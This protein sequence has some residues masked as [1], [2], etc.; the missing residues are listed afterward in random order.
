[1][2]GSL[3]RR[4][5]RRRAARRSLGGDVALWYHP[6]YAPALLARTCRVPSVPLRRGVLVLGELVRLGLLRAADVRAPQLASSEELLRVHPWNYLEDVARPEV[7][8]HIFGLDD[9]AAEADPLLLAQ[10]WAVGGT[11]A[12]ARAAAGLAGAP[13]KV[14]VNLGG[15]FHHAEPERG[16]GFCVYND[17][18]VAVAA[19]RDA[20]YDEPIAIVDLDF[21]QGDGNLVTFADDPSVLTFSLHGSV[22]SHIEAVA[23]VGIELA[24]GTGD[25]AYLRLL[26]EQLPAALAAHEPGL[27]FFLSGTDVL[28]GD[29]LG[30]FALSPAGVLARDRFVVESAQAQGCAL[31]VTLAGGYRDD[32]WLCTASLLHGLLT[33]EYRLLARPP[34]DVALHFREVAASLDPEEL[35]REEE[36]GAQWSLTEEEIM[37]ELGERPPARRLLDYYS[38]HGI[39]YALQR[40]G[41]FAGVE[42]RGFVNVR[43]AWEPRDPERQLL[44]LYGNKAGREHILVELVLRRRFLRAPAG[45]AGESPLELLS[46]EWLLLQDPSRSFT[47]ARPALPG[48]IHPGLNM[49]REVGELFLR[50]CLR[51]GLDGVIN[52]P[53]HY[54][55]AALAWPRMRFLDPQIEGRFRAMRE[56][57][58]DVPLHEASLAVA[59]GNG[60]APWQPADFVQPVSARLGDYLN[61]TSYEQAAQAAKAA[62]LAEVAATTQRPWALT[63]PP[64][65]R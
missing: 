65:I 64:G 54:H 6:A 25:A 30:D 7:L 28:A 59:A 24:A 61:A 4:W 11:L 38:Q 16:A 14:A 18:A 53:S 60:P 36:E 39:E 41:I 63:S 22:W 15:G 1:M 5:R 45:L 33:G 51:L 12:A 42:A 52:H 3:W 29:P 13:V 55:I 37:G 20:G 57:L 10:R 43:L 44:R 2:A 32:A 62:L 21:H 40:Y 23:D 34:L 58:A 47:L 49:V 46:L 26:Q 56:L 35:Q 19:L 17:V 27:L 31:V 48:Q 8:A 9:C 50:V